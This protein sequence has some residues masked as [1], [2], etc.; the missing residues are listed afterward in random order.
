MGY[1]FKSSRA[2]R[3]SVIVVV[4]VTLMLASLMLVKFMESTAVE[5]TLATRH[6]DRDRL[7]GDAYAALETA[8]AV[9]A[10]IKA[11]DEGLQSPAQGWGDPYAYAGENPREG[12]TATF[13][14]TDESGKASLPNLTAEEL[15]GLAEALGLTATDARR[16]T[17]GLLVWTKRD[18]VP[19]DIEAEASNYERAQ[20]PHQPPLRGLRSWDE[21]RAVRVARDFVYHEDGALT[22]FG[23]A[24]RAN[25][26]LYAF[27]GSNVNSLAPALGVARGWDPSQLAL[28][29]DYRA[30][31][32]GRPAGAPPWFRNVSELG[33]LLGANADTSKLDA[34]VKLL[35]VRVEV[36]EGAASAAL[37][38]WVA[39]DDQVALPAATEGET[40]N[41]ANAT[42]P[43]A[44]ANGNPR[45]R[46][47]SRT[48]GNAQNQTEEKLNYPFT[49]LE[50]VESSGPDADV[51]INSDLA[52][53][54]FPEPL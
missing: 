13:T 40:A 2:R 41:A 35:R 14:F 50:L 6:A 24:L 29:K 9:M 18:H 19:Q 49:I 42:S 28:I 10:E 26:S 21:L 46:P 3:G 38:A 4:L 32:T 8:L 31:R 16:F 20:L 17:D 36:R 12:V 44:T 47:A 52:P 7:R 30:G 53:D 45:S 1:T 27:T 34:A 37:V 39:M 48:G 15:V 23:V 25:V 51:T 33:P 43:A 5:L 54:T 11:L 22:P